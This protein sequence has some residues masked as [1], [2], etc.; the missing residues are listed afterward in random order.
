MSN[1]LKRLALLVSVF[2]FIVVSFPASLIAQTIT[3]LPANVS[4]LY[5]WENGPT[6]HSGGWVDTQWMASDRIQVVSDFGQLGGKAIKVTVNPGDDPINSSGERAELVH[7]SNRDGTILDENI[8]SGTQYYAVSIKLPTD[9]VEPAKEVNGPNWAIFLQLHGDDKYGMSPSFAMDIKD[10]FQVDNMGGDLDYCNNYIVT[11][12]AKCNFTFYPLSDG[13]LNLGHWVYFV[14]KIKFAKDFTGSI[15]VWR[16]NEGQSQFTQVLSKSN[17]PTLQYRGTINNGI[18]P[19]HYWKTGFYRSEQ[20]TLINVIYLGS[21]VRGSTFNDVVA[22]AFPSTPTATP[23]LLKGDINHDG[24]VN[25]QDFTLLSN[26]FGTNNAAADLN[27]DGI[28]NIQD[29]TLLSNNFG[30]TS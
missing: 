1:Y 19:N 11:D 15:D 20:T 16:A 22:A 24:T 17:I 26:A 18:V 13:S 21:I 14:I 23:V 28:V 30:K 12:P 3:P 6:N 2:S 4:F 29:Y 9:W 7:M 5:D 27:S 8:P 25:I 10:A